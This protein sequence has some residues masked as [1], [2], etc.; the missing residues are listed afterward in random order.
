ME[1]VEKEMEKLR[2]VCKCL[3][4]INKYHKY[5]MEEISEERKMFG[6]IGYFSV[7]ACVARVMWGNFRKGRKSAEE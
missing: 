2:K 5:T 6:K 7:G 3:I 4:T 1:E